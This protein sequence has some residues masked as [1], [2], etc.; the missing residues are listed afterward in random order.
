[1]RT[2]VL[3]EIHGRARVGQHLGKLRRVMGGPI[4]RYGHDLKTT[5]GHFLFEL[6]RGD[7]LLRQY[8]RKLRQPNTDEAG[9][10][11]DIQDLC[12]RHRRKRIP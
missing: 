7:V 1:M 8:A 11:H 9:I 3:Q 6:C 4:E 12:E 10:A 2:E 5:L